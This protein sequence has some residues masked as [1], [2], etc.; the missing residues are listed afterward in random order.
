MTPVCWPAASQAE[1]KLRE[2]LADKAALSRELRETQAALA[3]LQQ[4]QAQAQ[5]LQRRLPNGQLPPAAAA[6]TVSVEA[7]CGHCIARSKVSATFTG[8]T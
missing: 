1:G 5:P 3:F 4:Q 8:P 6:V 7:C 2:A